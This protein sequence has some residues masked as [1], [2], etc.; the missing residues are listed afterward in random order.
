MSFTSIVFSEQDGLPQQICD[1]CIV[2]ALNAFKFKRRCEE[3]DATLRS[4][5]VLNTS[6]SNQIKDEVFE[7]GALNHVN[8]EIKIKSVVDNANDNKK[9][10]FVCKICHKS[11]LQHQGL[12]LH[13]RVHTGERPFLCNR[14]GKGFIRSDDL[15]K[16]LRIHTG[17]RPFVC[18]ICNKGF[19]QKFHLSEHERS[20]KGKREL[21][22]KH[23]GK[24]FVRYGV[25][26]THM[27]I[28]SGL[29]LYTCNICSKKF[30]GSDTLAKHI[31]THTGEKPY[32]CSQ[33]SRRF[34]QIDQLKSHLHTHTDLKQYV[35][36]VC[37]K[38][39]TQQHGLDV[40][41]LSH[42]GERPFLCST[43]GKLFTRLDDLKKHT[44]THSQERPY[45]CT[46]CPK[47]FTQSFHLSEHLRT[48]TTIQ[49]FSCS[50]CN[51]KFTR[52]GSLRSHL[53]LMMMKRPDPCK[54]LKKYYATEKHQDYRIE[55][56]SFGEVN[57]PIG[58]YYGAGTAR[59]VIH[60]PIGDELEKVP[61][62]MVRAYGI[63]KKAAACVNQ[64]YSLN[65][66]I[67]TFIGKACD[68]IIS[69][70]LY[71]DHFPS[72]VWSTTTQLH[73]NVNEVISNRAIELLGGVIGSKTPIHPNDHVNLGQSSNDTFPTAMHIAVAQEINNKLLPGLQLLCEALKCKAEEFKSI[74][75]V[76]RTHM[77][78]AVPIT[79]GQEFSGY[80]QQVKFGI[81]RIN[82]VLPRLY[83]LAMGGTAVGT[84][85]N[86]PKGFP[87]K[88]CQQIAVLTNLPFLLAP[89][90]FEAVSA[91]DSMV[92]VSGALNVFATSY[93]KIAN[94][95]KLLCSG[96]RA[97]LA[98]IT[99]PANEPGSSIMGGKANPTQCDS[100]SMVC[101]HII[102]AHV[103]VTIGGSC[104]HLDLNTCKPM[105]VANVLRSI[106]ILAD[107][108]TAFTEFCVNGIEPNKEVL[109]RYLNNCL[110]LATALNPHIGYEKATAIAK[111]AQK[112]NISLKE[113]GIKLRFLT[114]KQFD[115]WIRPERMVHPWEK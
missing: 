68:E 20:H 40:H 59:A 39:F 96:P 31:R 108:T 33:C 21:S 13:M 84:G 106:K 51:K 90:L 114:E 60:F 29:K 95:I 85:L 74:I 34:S 62:P 71:K 104:A 25:L 99:I 44:R 15:L 109:E 64:E 1:E 32:S 82:D 77:Q 70:K 83:L 92:E 5:L 86:A 113:A 41:M 112:E 66:E 103:S 37:F 100:A 72:I 75:K 56:D 93:L 9:K 4:T 67:A 2:Q 24:T 18:K 26:H 42:T 76:G 55:T 22:C 63:L 87:E 7:S 23:C 50:I 45:L 81:N 14:C 115:D 6:E 98:E 102:G 36:D 79:L 3:V 61:F 57:V 19:K 88:C 8:D 48:H 28:H 11:Y 107:S 16:H 43:C 46:H 111:L 52:S 78:D 47:A 27:R 49:M 35:C 97:G 73:M 54:P 17:E 91:D 101:A 65:K 89:N 38:A 10:L 12:K 58:K 69:G 110:M 80:A 53:P 94:D 30:V 105:M